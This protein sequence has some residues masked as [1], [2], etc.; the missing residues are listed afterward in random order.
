MNLNS[1]IFIE[2]NAIE[3]AIVVCQNGVRGVKFTFWDDGTFNKEIDWNAVKI[4]L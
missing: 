2:E 3:N 4:L 1:I